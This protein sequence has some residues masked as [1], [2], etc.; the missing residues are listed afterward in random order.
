MGLPVKVGYDTT[1]GDLFEVLE[2]EEQDCVVA[3]LGDDLA[4]LLKL[5]YDKAF[6]DDDWELSMSMFSCLNT[7]TTNSLYISAFILEWQRE[8]GP[9][10]ADIACMHE[11]VENKDLIRI[12]TALND[13]PLTDGEAGVMFFQVWVGLV[14]CIPGG[15]FELLFLGNPPDDMSEK[16]ASCY[17]SIMDNHMNVEVLATWLAAYAMPVG[18][19]YDDGLL[20]KAVEFEEIVANCQSLEDEQSP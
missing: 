18:V 19:P 5:R 9:I 13:R 1:W 3:T 14:T 8:E 6:G 16:E 15:F 12:V 4:E 20:G 7:M 17:Q 10:K 11:M 2:P